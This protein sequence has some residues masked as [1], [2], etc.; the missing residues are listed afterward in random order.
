MQQWE[1]SQATCWDNQR[2]A[3]DSWGQWEISHNSFLEVHSHQAA[4]GDPQVSVALAA[5]QAA[6]PLVQ[7]FQPCRHTCSPLQEA[8]AEVAAAAVVEADQDQVDMIWDQA[9]PALPVVEAEAAEAEAV[10]RQAAATMLQELTHMCVVA[11]APL[12]RL[13]SIARLAK[14]TLH[15]DVELLAPS[16]MYT[17]T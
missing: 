3:A 2:Q 4:T 6:F 1:H 9:F 5:F 12:W 8:A 16:S 7:I 10:A 11:A 13:A 17:C 15:C 14:S